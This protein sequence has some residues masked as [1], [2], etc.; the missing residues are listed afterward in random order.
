M[1]RLGLQQRASC[2]GIP[3]LHCG[4]LVCYTI[5]IHRVEIGDQS[6]AGRVPTK[7]FTRLRTG[8]REVQPCEHRH[9]AEMLRSL[10]WRDRHDWQLEAS[11]KRLCDLASLP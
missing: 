3:A 2:H 9:P 5:I 4:L 10:L 7:H 11:A 6:G 1:K 8:S